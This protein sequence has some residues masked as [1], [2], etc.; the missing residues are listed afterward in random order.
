MVSPSQH[1]GPGCPDGAFVRRLWENCCTETKATMVLDSL[2]WVYL[3][4][5]VG[6][7]ILETSLHMLVGYMI[8]YRCDLRIWNGLYRARGSLQRSS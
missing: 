3:V 4:S 6:Y 8:L 1:V 2:S 5:N 7:A